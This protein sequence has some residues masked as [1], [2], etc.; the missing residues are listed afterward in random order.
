MP[1]R[2]LKNGLSN[3]RKAF[4]KERAHL[5][6]LFQ[7][8]TEA[9]VLVDKKGI[10]EK[11][12]TEFLELFGYASGE[13]LGQ[14]IDNLI[15]PG[16]LNRNAAN[17]TALVISG[18][19]QLIETRRCRKDGRMID[20]SVLASP[21]SVEGTLVGYYG[22]Y[23]DISERKN[24]ELL[25]RQEKAYL[26]HLFQGL[27]EAIVLV[28]K[29]GIIQRANREFESLFGYPVHEVLGKCIDDLVAPEDYNREAKGITG[30]V[31][32]GD[33][34]LIETKRRRMDG[35][36][37]DVSVLASPISVEGSLEGYYGIY[38]DITERKKA[39]ETLAR[40]R[41]RIEKLHSIARQLDCCSSETES[42]NITLSAASSLLDFPVSSIAVVRKD[43]LTP[44]AFSDPVLEEILTNHRFSPGS[45]LIG[46]SFMRKKTL[47]T[48]RLPEE[49]ESVFKADGYILQIAAPIGEYGV[50][51][52]FRTDDRRIEDE[53]ISL[54]ELLLNYSSEAIK[55]IRLVD[56]L[57][58]QAI[59]DPL[60]GLYNRNYFDQIIQKVTEKAS[61]GKH[62]VGIVMI[63]IDRFKLVNDRLGHQRGDDILKMVANALRTVLRKEDAIFRYGGDEFL[64][65]LHQSEGYTP[66]VI[67]RFREAV[68]GIDSGS[69]I[70]LTLSIGAVLWQPGE[71][72]SIDTALSN[73]DALMYE[74]K[75]KKQISP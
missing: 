68:S 9:I 41:W 34:K 54:L 18:H 73:A 32:S 27:Q 33:S 29:D 15:A 30:S 50:F 75:Q 21:I 31:I 55:R 35:K 53:Q 17:I 7:C 71:E 28:D 14:S 48:D 56:E 42:Y 65:I 62:S 6:H 44:I 74:D 39:V 23:H 72:V 5:T 36:L 26:E 25:L 37:I 20:V 3:L 1:D 60:T 13:V 57:R 8:L 40:S 64:A 19:K 45:S 46:R 24:A 2:K 58:E 16:D 11:V 10:V 47:L 61:S 43:S 63:D 59:H 66:R 67:Q 70:R 22:V 4:E 51:L 49:D 69:D 52:G 38:R 12:N